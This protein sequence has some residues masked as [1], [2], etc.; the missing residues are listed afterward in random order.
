M[1]AGA[2][3]AS[4]CAVRA[5]AIVAAVARPSV[6]PNCCELLISPLASPACWPAPR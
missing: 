2:P 6:P 4:A 3:L 5:E 1:S